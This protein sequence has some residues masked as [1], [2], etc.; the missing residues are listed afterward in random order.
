M[1]DTGQHQL[2]AADREMEQRAA[3]AKELLQRRYSQLQRNQQRKADRRLT[4]EKRMSVADGLA[5]S[6]KRV[7]R[8]ELARGEVQAEKEFRRR[9]TPADFEPLA[10]IGRGAFGE[11]TLV[12]RCRSSNTTTA[13]TGGGNNAAE[14][15]AYGKVYALK[16]MNKDRMVRKNQVHHIKAEREALSMAD[17]RYQWLTHLHYSFQDETTLYMVLEY[18]PGGDLMSLLIREDTFSEEAT[19][20]LMAEAAHA[21]SAIHALGYIHRDVKPDNFLIDADGHLKLTD[22][23]LCKRVGDVCPDE[24]PTA[25]LRAY[26]RTSS[27]KG[28]FCDDDD[29]APASPQSCITTFS[30]EIGLHALACDDLEEPTS[31]CNTT[32]WHRHDRDHLVTPERNENRRQLAKTV[33]G[34]PDYIAPEVLT[35]DSGSNTYDC[36]VDWWSLGCIMFECLAGYPPFYSDEPVSTCRKILRWR[37]TL[38]IPSR[39]RNR[40]STECI[41][42]LSCLI[43]D[44]CRRV[45]ST[46]HPDTEFGTNGFAQIVNHPWYSGFDWDNLGKGKGPLL[47]RGSDTF[48]ALI[49]ELKQCPSHDPS[50]KS[51][52]DNLTVN[53]DSFGDEV[54]GNWYASDDTDDATTQS[55]NSKVGVPFLDSEFYDYH[56]TRHRS[57]QVP[58]IPQCFDGI[59]DSSI[60]SQQREEMKV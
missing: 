8:T 30:D 4:L 23:G 20:F 31:T 9:V 47:P 60:V 6:Q 40:L 26:R 44:S 57:P 36:S 48:P 28:F 51:I 29:S 7:L 5:E 42:F 21:I 52:V 43:T 25:V 13:A 54:A 59:A 14:S 3:R 50:F 41:D 16:S 10:V 34:T 22:L 18:M 1:T 37:E 24:S 38:R 45:G 55:A 35:A 49:E 11:V 39:T 19:K 17:E 46:T 2:A 12:R 56:F 32:A 27:R 15:V 53:F 33:V 58:K